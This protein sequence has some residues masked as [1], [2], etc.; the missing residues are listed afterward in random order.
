MQDLDGNVWFPSVSDYSS[1]VVHALAKANFD[2][3]ALE[4][5]TN[6]ED[7]FPIIE[8]LAV[9]D[10]NQLILC[11]RE[12]QFRALYLLDQKTF[13][14]TRKQPL[15]S[16][17][18][19]LNEEPRNESNSRI[20]FLG[21]RLVSRVLDDL[22]LQPLHQA[23]KPVVKMVSGAG[24]DIFLIG[25]SYLEVFNNQAS[26]WEIWWNKED[27]PGS[28]L[29]R[30]LAYVP[31]AFCRNK[32][33]FGDEE[34]LRVISP[35]PIVVDPMRSSRD[36]SFSFTVHSSSSV[37][38]DIDVSTNLGQWFPFTNLTITDGVSK[39]MDAT[40]SS[41]SNRFYRAKEAD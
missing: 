13:K 33:Y 10:R 39:F 11:G 16:G 37:T 3:R 41:L 31:A 2:Q 30:H 9:F 23:S 32:L 26:K 15:A 35:T 22:T 14:I 19:L 34:K 8:S 12:D 7:A 27:V 28:Y 5:K 6:V 18:V 29:F 25:K 17:G 4:V 20:L 1:R 38:L 36:G 21:D 40:A 24:G